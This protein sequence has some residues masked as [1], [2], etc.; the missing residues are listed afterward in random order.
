MHLKN[1]STTSLAGPG[2]FTVQMPGSPRRSSI[3]W[4]MASLFRHS[5]TLIYADP[6]RQT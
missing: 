2:E 3:C 6:S 5:G 1:G 4:L